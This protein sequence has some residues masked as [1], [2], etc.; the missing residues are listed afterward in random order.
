MSSESQMK[1]TR[2]S[3]RISAPRAAVWR[4]LLEEATYKEWTAVFAGGSYFE[5]NWSEGSTIRFLTPEKDGMV[6]VIAE[7]REHEFVSIKH[8]GYV[9]KGVDDTESDAVKTWAPAFENYTLNEVDGGTELVVEME[10]TSAEEGYFED[11]MPKA[12][13]IIKKLAET[14]E[15]S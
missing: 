4:V 12:L 9:H 7:N 8:L 14:S 5:G 2:H 11:V 1:K 10:I 3:I 13:K 6:G 15:E